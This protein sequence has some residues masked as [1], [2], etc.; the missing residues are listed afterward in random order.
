MQE[1]FKTFFRFC[2]LAIRPIRKSEEVA[3]VLGL[4]V[5]FL[6]ILGL[7]GAS[8]VG[9]LAPSPLPEPSPHWPLIVAYPMILLTILFLIAG[10]RLQHRLS[11]FDRLANIKSGDVVKNKDLNLSLLVQPR[12]KLALANITF[13]RCK[14]Y[15]PC[16][17]GIL[18]NI[19]LIGCGFFSGRKLD[20]MIIEVK[21]ARDFAGIAAFVYCKFHYCEFYDISWL[22]DKTIA[23]ELRKMVVV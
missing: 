21:E 18:G 3:G 5:T 19:E 16:T 22:V 7:V 1:Y 23:D 6:I 8:V 10:L 14:F 9:W 2:W 20:D 17:V 11:A 13:E 12:K 15:G 4:I